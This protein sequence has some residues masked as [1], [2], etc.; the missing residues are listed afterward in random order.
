MVLK[1]FLPEKMFTY[2]Q[3]DEMTGFKKDLWTWSNKG[4]V[5]LAKMGFTVE[6]IQDF[7]IEEFARRG[8]P[9]LMDYF[10]DEAGS[11]QIF[12]SDIPSEQKIAKEYIQYIH[13]QNRIPT[14][15]D[16]VSY[17]KNG[18]LIICNV[19][20]QKLYGIDGYVAHDVVVFN[21]LDTVL[22]HDPGLPRYKNRKVTKSIFEKAWAYPDEKAKNI[23][24]IKYGGRN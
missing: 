13:H 18:F 24:A 17:L 4:M 8:E 21:V 1:F 2:K 11:E 23:I 12:R 20:A 16:I 7:D 19:N 14:L 9:M 22:I 3:L 5:A 15:N 6:G 10:G